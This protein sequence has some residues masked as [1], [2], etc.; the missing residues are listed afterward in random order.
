MTPA[1]IAGYCV[2]GGTLRC[3]GIPRPG[4]TLTCDRC[5]ASDIH[6]ASRQPPPKWPTPRWQ[7]SVREGDR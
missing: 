1:S 2:C 6:P 7:G 3:D 5:G 4:Y